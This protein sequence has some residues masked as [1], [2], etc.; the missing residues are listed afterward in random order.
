MIIGS[1]MLP[2]IAFVVP[3]AIIYSKLGIIDTKF[4]LIMAHLFF[5]LPFA[6]WLL[7]GFYASLPK[8]LEDAARIDGCTNFQTFWRVE[9][10]LVRSGVI[11][12][13]ILA[14]L[15][16]WWEYPFAVTLMRQTN[17]TL[18]VGIVT[19]FKDDFVIWNHLAA[20]TIISVIP[21]VVFIIFFQRFIVAGMV[22][23]SVKE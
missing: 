1:R 20:A 19:I 13:A 8:E 16:S 21:G 10:P 11:A 2:S 14:F 23:G 15:Y 6:I 4:G 12:A 18:P 3:F 5:T 9:M 17:R 7:E 22:Q